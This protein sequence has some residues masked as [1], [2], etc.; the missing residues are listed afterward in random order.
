M[1]AHPA[2]FRKNSMFGNMGTGLQWIAS[3]RIDVEG[4]CAVASPADCQRVYQDTLHM[5]LPRLATLFDWSK[6]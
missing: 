1:P 4:L 2:D 6:V 5:R 3:G